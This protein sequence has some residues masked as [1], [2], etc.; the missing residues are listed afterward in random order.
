[1][2]RTWNQVAVDALYRFLPHEQA[3]IGA[4]YN[5]VTGEARG[6]GDVTMN[7]FAVA[8]GWF[9]TQNLLLKLEYVNQDYKNFPTNDYR[10]GG[11]FKGMMVEA[12]IGL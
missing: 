1:M 2:K 7:R 11:N 12:V 8:A 6:L 3:Y 5:T 9:P 10:Y 4:R